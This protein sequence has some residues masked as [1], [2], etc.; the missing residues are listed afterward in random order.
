MKTFKYFLVF[1]ILFSCDKKEKPKDKN[2]LFL[3]NIEQ[4]N[5]Y[6]KAERRIDSL[7]K[8]GLKVELSITILKNSF[9]APDSLKNSYSAIINEDLGFSNNILFFVH[10]NKD[11]FEILSI[12][13]NK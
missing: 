1:I 10:Y 13:S 4:L 5:E 7:K 11:T 6:K 3:E 12:T 9:Y 8:T 2:I